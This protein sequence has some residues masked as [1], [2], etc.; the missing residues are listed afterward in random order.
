MDPDRMS[1]ELPE[2]PLEQ[3]LARSSDAP[4]TPPTAVVTEL[5]FAEISPPVFEKVVA[6]VVLSADR[7]DDVH[8][9]GRSGQD[10]GGLDI[11]G[12]KG[13]ELHVYQVRRI[14][15]LTP[16]ALRKAVVDFAGPPRTTTQKKEWTP[17]RFEAHRFVVTTGCANDDR[18]VTDELG[19]LKVEYRGDLDIALYDS[20][21]LSIRLRHHGALVQS[22]FGDAWSKAFCG[23]EPPAGTGVGDG[24][25]LL[26]DPLEALGLTDTVTQAREA[27]STSPREAAQVYL[28][29]AAALRDAYLPFADTYDDQATALFQAAGDTELAFS[30]TVDSLITRNMSGQWTGDKL[31]TAG[32]L[33]ESLN[34]EAAALFTVVRAA[35]EWFLHGF[36]LDSVIDCID[37]LIA[38]RH[39]LVD[40]AALLIAEQVLTDEDPADDVQRLADSLEKLPRQLT[41]Q[42]HVR[43][44]CCIADL[45]IRGGATVKDAYGELYEEAVAAAHQDAT[46]ALIERRYGRAL[47]QTDAFVPAQNAYRRAVV[48]AA[49]AKLGADVRDALRSIAGLAH[50][51]NLI[52]FGGTRAMQA[53]QATQN[54]RQLIPGIDQASILAL[55]AIADDKDREAVH[56]CHHWLR[57]ERISGGYYDEQVARRHYAQALLQAQMPVLAVRQLVQASE[58]KRAAAAAAD[59]DS[60]VDLTDQLCATSSAIRASSC[61]VHTALADLIPDAE[62]GR[63]VPLLE[64]VFARAHTAE[65]VGTNEE[66]HALEGIAA[67]HWRIPIDT[68]VRV[69]TLVR[70]LLP[71]EPNHYR[72]T[73]RAVLKFLSSCTE[74][75]EKSVVTAAIDMLAQTLQYD[76]GHADHYISALDPQL[77]GL[78]LAMEDTAATGN[79][80]AVNILAGWG[81]GTSTVRDRAIELT[82][83]LMAEPVG[84]PRNS[85]VNGRSCTLAAESLTSTLKDSSADGPP[86]PELT[87]IKQAYVANLI[88]RV[89]DPHATAEERADAA[90]A[91]RVLEDCL[92]EQTRQDLWTR[93]LA[94]YD[95]PGEHPL[96]AWE[97]RSNHPLSN[98]RVKSINTFGSEL[99][100]TCAALATTPDKVQ[101][102]RTRLRSDMSRPARS[103]FIA[104]IRARTALAVDVETTDLVIELMHQSEPDSRKAAAVLWARDPHREPEIGLI[105]ARDEDRG[106]RA[107]VGQCLHDFGIH[108]QY[109]EIVE[110]LSKDRSA[111][112]R[113]A[114]RPSGLS[115]VPLPNSEADR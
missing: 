109:P 31:R 5:P 14:D 54:T 102:V 53:A 85:H 66:I 99:L 33:A 43:L 55:E 21:R 15:H 74:S 96:D 57:L 65:S 35:N 86:D 13:H 45:R 73:D 19:K 113:R 110:T 34:G 28:E 30:R 83:K 94:I 61:A 72:F 101:A 38:S 47:A 18:H 39:P 44:R 40:R 111:A 103:L 84:V 105:L 32:E 112:V 46:S 42:E 107:T 17:R 82:T 100:W 98:F 60:F 29:V 90:V 78:Q 80:W 56:R 89:E 114:S 9:Y 92:S 77:P 10:Q 16:S 25:G 108:R 36:D 97:R 71:R 52:S 49:R 75:P 58:T 3:I 27:E 115:T 37:R 69:Q 48:D 68:A 93:V 70:D 7:L 50:Q 41:G 20:R 95:N 63:I 62:V 88:Q 8:I 67:L 91:I 59:L 64:R 79:V 51:P 26:N 4:V 87:E 6:E 22:V 76:F 1:D 104:E 2:I 106:V 11:V 24:H 23:Y 12:W 81:I